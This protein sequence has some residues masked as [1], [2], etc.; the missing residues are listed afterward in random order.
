MEPK[1]ALLFSSRL[2]QFKVA[3]IDSLIQRNISIL[4][5]TMDYAL[6]GLY[7][8]EDAATKDIPKVAALKS[9]VWSHTEGKWKSYG[10]L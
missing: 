2:M 1:Y 6:I 3:N 8:S 4:P 5:A 10:S 7:T 9:L